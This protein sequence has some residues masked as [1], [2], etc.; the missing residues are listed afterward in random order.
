[1]RLRKFTCH[2]RPLAAIFALVSIVNASAAT[3][4]AVHEEAFDGILLSSTATKAKLKASQLESY[5]LGCQGDL[6]Q[7]VS[8][9]PGSEVLEYQCQ[10]FLDRGAEVFSARWGIRLNLSMIARTATDEAITAGKFTASPENFL[11]QEFTVTEIPTQDL[12]PENVRCN[13]KLVELAYEVDGTVMKQ[14][15]FASRMPNYPFDRTWK[16][17]ARQ[18]ILV[19]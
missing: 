11:S 14:E 19:Q 12:E 5:A 7:L 9:V 3:T 4:S 17:E 18:V 16:I 1:M 13:E 15:C 6:R 8:S 2:T 10:G